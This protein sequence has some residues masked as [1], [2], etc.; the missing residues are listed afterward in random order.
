MVIVMKASI[1]HNTS[2][3]HNTTLVLTLQG[4]IPVIASVLSQSLEIF[5]VSQCQANLSLDIYVW[6]NWLS[7]ISAN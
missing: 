3:S 6:Q 5:S 1:Q 2:T 7:K 4:G